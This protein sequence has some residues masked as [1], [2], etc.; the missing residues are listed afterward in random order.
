TRCG[1]PC[2]TMTREMATLARS[3]GPNARFVTLTTDPENDTPT[4]MKEYSARFEADPKR[5]SFLTGPKKEIARL[6]VQ[7]LKFTTME[8][9]PGQQ[10]NEN[11]L[12][13][14]SSNFMVVDKKGRV[15]ASVES[16][17]P[18][19]QDTLLKIIKDLEREP[20]R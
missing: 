17:E 13:I 6:A 20:A 15:R 11:D 18:F 19:A 16:L 5:W 12:F 1:G 9:D 10:E 14:H 3:A 2:P 4:V 8:K 7:D